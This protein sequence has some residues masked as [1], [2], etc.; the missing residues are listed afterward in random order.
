M[1]ITS[2]RV[3][4]SK[5]IVDFIFDNKKNLAKYGYVIIEKE[6]FIESVYR[7]KKLCDSRT[8]ES[9]WK[10]LLYSGALQQR[11]DTKEYIFSLESVFESYPE[12]KHYSNMILIEEDK[13]LKESV[14]SRVRQKT[15][16]PFSL[17]V[18]EC[19]CDTG[20]EKWKK[21]VD[22]NHCFDFVAAVGGEA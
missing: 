12:I 20:I 19:V 2:Q 5:I 21:S 9:K 4:V 7:H 16:H 15:Q 22:E 13:K 18:S 1:R 8:I 3:D 10:Q 6:K 11:G 14:K 17:C